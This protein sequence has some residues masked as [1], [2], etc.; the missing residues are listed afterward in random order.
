[1]DIGESQMNKTD[2][3]VY[4]ATDISL[5][6]GGIAAALATIIY[7]LKHVKNSSCLGF[8]CSQV[9]VDEVVQHLDESRPPSPHVD[10]NLDIEA[11]MDLLKHNIVSHSQV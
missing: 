10:D 8:K 4:S 9:V 3:A 11:L 2:S 5:I 6:L 1:M 7:S